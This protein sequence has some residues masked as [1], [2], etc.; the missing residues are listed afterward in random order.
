MKV[1]LS[2]PLEAKPDDVRLI[3][4]GVCI[5]PSYGTKR[6][7]SYA[8]NIE[9]TTAGRLWAMVPGSYLLGGGWADSWSYGLVV[10]EDVKGS[11][12]IADKTFP[13]DVP[14]FLSADVP[15]VTFFFYRDPKTSEMTMVSDMTDARA[16]LRLMGTRPYLRNPKE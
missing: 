16:S 15:I 5:V 10:V 7:I 14:I 3:V 9:P 6:W 4:N 2:F 12:Q 13:L 8:S 1:W 11:V